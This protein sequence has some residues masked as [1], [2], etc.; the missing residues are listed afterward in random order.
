MVADKDSQAD[1]LTVTQV[2][3]HLDYTPQHV[4]L[5]LRE[6]RLSGT[7]IGR[8]WVVPSEAVDAFVA[9]RDTLDLPLSEND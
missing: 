8:D 7:K 6:G 4:R 9:R 2:A 1:L 3:Q 5:L